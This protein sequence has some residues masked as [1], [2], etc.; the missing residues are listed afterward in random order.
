[1]FA[2][3]VEELDR[4]FHR[5]AG[6]EMRRGVAAVWVLHDSRQEAVAGYYTLSTA[7]VAP[8]HLPEA[9]VRKLP[10]YP[11]LPTMLIGRLATDVRYRG[12]GFGKLLLFDA[13]RRALDLS[14][15][16]RAIAIMVDAKDAA[17]VRFYER[18]GFQ[19][20]ADDARRLFIPMAIV[21]MTLGE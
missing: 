20:F 7:S 14:H 16:I 13:L 21:I 18:Y 6:Q 10:R 19:R 5:Q 11:A 9:I 8:T 2:S 12:Q 4:Y 17:A 3:G 1:M 15:S